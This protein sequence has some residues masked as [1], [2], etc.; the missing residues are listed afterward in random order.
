MNSAD[1]QDNLKRKRVKETTYLMGSYSKEKIDQMI[2]ELK[3][4]KAAGWTHIETDEKY[5]YGEKSLIVVAT[6]MREENDIE[7]NERIKEEESCKE[8]RRLAY[9]QLK[10]EFEG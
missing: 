10:K 3:R 2:D 7:Y 9:E 4:L 1:R 6:K 5:D 8:S